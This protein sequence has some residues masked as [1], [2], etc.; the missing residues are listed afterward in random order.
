MEE[1]KPKVK[2][3]KIERI[4]L[5]AITLTLSLLFLNLHLVLKRDF[6]D[7]QK[8]LNEGTMVNL[9]AK[10]PG[11]HIKTLLE[12][13]YYFED[14]KD[15]LLI[16]SIV[17]KNLN[18]EASK[19]DNIGELNK[20]KYYVVADEAF[21]KGGSSFK[22]RVAGSR[23]LL[24]YTGDD[25]LLFVQEKT[26]PS[27]LQAH[28]DIALGQHNISGT[29]TNKAEKPISGVLIRLEMILPQDS[30]YSEQVTEVVKEAIEKGNGYKKVYVLDS[31]NNRQ[32][33]SLTAYARTDAKGKYTF[34]NLPDK[35]AFE[36]LP[37]QPGFQFGNSKG[38]QELESNV[39]LN[40]TQSPHTM[41]LLTSRDFN[42]IKKEKSLIVR[43]PQEFNKW[44]Y[45]ITGSFFLGFIIIH[46]LLCFK[47]PNADQLIV[48]VLMLLIGISLLTLLSLQDPLRDRF[49]A[50]NTL[51]YLGIGFLGLCSLLFINLRRFTV[52][53]SLYR[54][55]AFKNN[56]KAANGWPWAIF[57][58]VLL[59]L[60]ILLGTGPEGSGVK[61]NLFGFQPS[62]FV[63]FLILLFLA[64]FFATN[65]KFISEYRSWQKRWSFFSFALIAILISVLLFL[66]LG[67]LGPA[68]VICFTF[69]VLF[70]FSRGDFMFM[71]A[72]VVLY[73]LAVWII[74]NVWLATGLTATVLAVMMLFKRKALS[75]SALM[76][77]ILIAG[78]LL[79]DKIPY[80][81]QLI[82][83][84]VTRLVERKAIWQDA[85]NNEVYGG[86][87]VANG[88][89]AMSSG[90][91]TGQGAGEGFAK[92]IPEAHTDM[93]LPALGEEFGWTGI[94]CIFILFLIYLHRSIIIGRQTGTPFLFYLC[95]GIGI[96]TFIQFLLI[97][98]GSTGALPLSG[99]SL[100]M[101][102]YGGSSLVANLFAAGFLLSSSLVQGSAVQMAYITKQQDRNLV[103]AL[104][105]ACFG[106]LL[107]T[108]NVS[109]YLF[110][111]KKW[112]VQPSLVA[113]R[114]G[115][116]MFSYNPRIAILMN[117][118]Q[119]GSLYD[120]DG[121]ILATSK[122]ELIRSQRLALSQAGVQKYNLE[123]AVHKRL[124]R[125]Y[126]FEEQ[127]FFW[128]GDANTGI[129]NGSTNGYFA[130]YEHAAELRGFQTPTSNYNVIAN[131]Y[132]EDRFL[133]RGVKEMT[134]TK[135]DY[136]AL[137]PLLLA[138]INSKE[139]EDFKKRNR[140]VY[141]TL[142]ARLQT[143]IQK[144]IALDDSLKDN[145][146]SVVI[147]EANTGDVLTSAV[148]PL[149]PINDWDQLNMTNA[150]QNKLSQW[151]TT[152][153][154]GFTYAT[155]PGSTAKVLTTLAAFNKLGVAASQKTY[156]VSTNER[157]RTKGPEP[158]ETGKISLER[159]LVKSNNVYFIKLANEEK[160]Q[161]E[162][163]NLYLKTGMF[164]RGVGG[165]YYGKQV[166]NALQ[167]DKWRDLWRKTEFNTRPRYNPNNIR[168]TRAKGISGMAW[169]QGELIAT[170]AAVAR[171]IGGIANNGMLIPNR[172]VSKISDSLITSKN[173]IQLA[174]DPKYASIISDFM[175]KQSENKTDILKIAVAGKTGTPERVWKKE[176]I[177]D[178]WYV[179]FAPK[180][181]GSG[182]IVVCVR[183]E[184]TKGSS[185]A[186]KLAGKHVIPFL[187]EKKYIKSFKD[188]QPKIISNPMAI[189]TL[190]TNLQ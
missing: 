79:I 35:K 166:N 171:F 178:G 125:Y 127:M 97:A 139:V 96:S 177:N 52:D 122:P 24:G 18:T 33:Q 41:R 168:Q 94:I 162:M 147:M 21:D 59:F 58:I 135:K 20:R 77:V 95:T 184:S 16:Q 165:Y 51:M 83:G 111:N 155:Q 108:V 23:S 101:V 185:D 61:V 55:F 124:E 117:K 68:M 53:S 169:G 25:S 180:V 49:L 179:F 107:L 4:F 93:I 70:S 161:E 92:N 44:Y 6:K 75:E 14:K 62:E 105:A 60:T 159:A 32:L 128:I 140:D 86:D 154:L 131:R 118:L 167:E 2:S 187:L 42:I 31:A 103:P 144:S 132:R 22:K 157:I 34:K 69:I 99:V 102:S 73:V 64:G 152:T 13:G 7:V 48:P 158:D 29:I 82:P 87:H 85:W 119:A 39:L 172:Y 121:R 45:I 149:P 80:L 126:P 174:N 146:V 190:K 130:E 3:R 120:R 88:I 72:A 37:L 5:V 151:I 114:S 134:V 43:T 56:R 137:A 91:L 50:K 106:I 12:K 143:S 11:E 136:S 181:S 47:F 150:E 15:V 19:I 176:R 104:I 182:N 116:R 81:D 189:D 67:D 26:Q 78:F 123:S 115:S 65:E 10:N 188:L 27:P 148:Y 164:L 160:L 110:N 113:D 142:D 57:A 28:V 90:G 186:V 156:T 145:R 138:G 84:P 98:G 109:R 175:I 38:V 66:A 63:K 133:P 8:R 153:D 9:N 112:V 74:D 76:T 173:G 46:L 71:V 129:F 141:L 1:D 89:W 36:I 54:M 40:F 100:P 30:A 163:G 183:I 170:P 17:T